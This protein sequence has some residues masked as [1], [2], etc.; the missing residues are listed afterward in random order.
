[1]LLS[2]YSYS[3]YRDKMRQTPP[4]F[5][6]ANTVANTD[7]NDNNDKK[8]EDAS[9]ALYYFIAFFVLEVFLL[10]YTIPLAMKLAQTRGEMIIHLFFAIF[11]APAYMFVAVAG[12]ILN[13]TLFGGGVVA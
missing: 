11:A 6:F 9:M 12:R 3:L 5:F 8:A 1:M 13:Y 2:A 4:E 10:F 7:N